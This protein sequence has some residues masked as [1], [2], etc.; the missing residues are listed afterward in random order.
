MIVGPLLS[1]FLAVKDLRYAYLA[2]AAVCI[3]TLCLVA[4]IRETLPVAAREPFR[5]ATATPLEVLKLFRNGR[6]LALLST[7][8]ILDFFV[9]GL[10][11]VTSV[12]QMQVLEWDVMLRGQFSSVS[13]I[14]ETPSYMVAR[15]LI[16]RCG[17]VPAVRLG[18]LSFI[19]AWSRRLCTCFC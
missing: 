11:N 19:G 12:H 6:Q 9:Q 1:G 16:R 3:P 5:W 2:S 18:F 17:M 14:A 4:T 8:S 7:I 10:K 15:P 13:S